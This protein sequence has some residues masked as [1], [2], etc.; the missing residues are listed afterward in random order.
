M[1]IHFSV[2]YNYKTTKHNFIKS[3]TR[4]LHSVNFISVVISQIEPLLFIMAELNFINFLKKWT[5]QKF[6]T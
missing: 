1:S 2:Y 4:D 5:I 6:C 3:G